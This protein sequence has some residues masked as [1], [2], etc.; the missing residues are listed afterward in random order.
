MKTQLVYHG[1]SLKNGIQI[2]KD[3]KLIAPLGGNIFVTTNKEYAKEYGPTIFKIKV[4]ISK[5]EKVN[6]EGGYGQLPLTP[7]EKRYVNEIAEYYYKDRE[8]VIN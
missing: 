3:G 2:K 6:W 8:L 5:I 7:E 1:T 4:P